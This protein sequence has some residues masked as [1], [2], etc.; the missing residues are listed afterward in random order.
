[1]SKSSNPKRVLAFAPV[2]RGFGFAVLESPTQLIES[3]VKS[4][5]RDEETILGKIL[6]L[7]QHY[8][9]DIIVVG[10]WENSR[11]C[12]RIKGVLAGICTL[13]AREGIK[14]RRFSIKRVKRVF[15][16]FHAE[17][18]QEIAQ[19]IARQ[20]PMLAHVLPLPRKPWM[21][22]DYQMPAFDAVALALTYFYSRPVRN[23]HKTEPTL[24]VDSSLNDQKRDGS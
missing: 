19:E 10:D 24:L 8:Q 6:G 17:T 15:E 20:L 5:R 18:K 16:A 13:A 1:M 7:V 9:P 21:T 23:G 3:A 22:E 12:L 11:R 4:A 14:C 2:S